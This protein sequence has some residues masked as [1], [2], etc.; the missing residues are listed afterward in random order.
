MLKRLK[1]IDNLYNFQSC[2]LLPTVITLLFCNF[3]FHHHWY[4]LSDSGIEWQRWAGQTNL[5]WTQSAWQSATA[6]YSAPKCVVWFGSFTT[7]EISISPDGTM[8]KAPPRDVENHFFFMGCTCAPAFQFQDFE[9]ANRSVRSSSLCLHSLNE[10]EVS[11][12]FI[13]TWKH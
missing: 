8:L 10:G 6:V 1:L 2:S 3:F 9:L 12:I 11:P 5:P 13:V 7:K 4:F